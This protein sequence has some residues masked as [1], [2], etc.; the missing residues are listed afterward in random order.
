MEAGHG[1]RIPK[2]FG[3]SPASSKRFGRGKYSPININ[4]VACAI[5]QTINGSQIPAFDTIFYKR[6]AV[7]L[8]WPTSRHKKS[9][10]LLR[11]Y[12]NENRGNIRERVQ[13]LIQ[14]QYP[15]NEANS[16]VLE[17]RDSPKLV[18]PSLDGK[19]TRKRKC[20]SDN[21][22]V[23]DTGKRGIALYCICKTPYDDNYQ[24]M[25]CDG[26]SNWYHYTCMNIPRHI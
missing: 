23:E 12:W 6:V 1:E 9:V 19:R 17:S 2:L 3:G 14:V 25:E 22:L 10:G 20:M 16:M 11:Q 13:E 5:V 21:W 15:A 24:Y 18:L 4:D 8:E 26:C 7:K